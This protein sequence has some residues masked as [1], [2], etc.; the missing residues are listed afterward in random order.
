[1]LLLGYNINDLISKI[2]QKFCSKF[3]SMGKL[4]VRVLFK[5]VAKCHHHS[6]LN[7][8]RM[9]NFAYINPPSMEYSKFHTGSTSM[10]SISVFG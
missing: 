2:K 3:V 8:T 1:M 4:C 10:H 5:L 9:I 6:I 7:N